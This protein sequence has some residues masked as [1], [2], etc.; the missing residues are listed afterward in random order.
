MG[1]V[2]ES[3]FYCKPGTYRLELG[4]GKFERDLKEINELAKGDLN[5]NDLNRLVYLYERSAI[6][7]RGFM[8]YNEQELDINPYLKENFGQKKF[9][10]N[11]KTFNENLPVKIERKNDCI[12]IFT[13]YLFKRGMKE[14]F[15]ISSYLNAELCKENNKNLFYDINYKKQIVVALR[16]AEKYS[17]TRHK[18]NDNMEVSEIINV[19]FRHMGLSDNAIHTSFFS[20]FIISQD[21]SEYGFHIFV[22]PYNDDQLNYKGRTLLDYFK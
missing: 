1:I 18:D 5:L 15:Y 6:S 4:K 10:T 20:D 11:K 13:P 2:D 16:V 7:L 22:I 14:S 8:E 3:S 21:E 12:H 9:K 17:H 19:L